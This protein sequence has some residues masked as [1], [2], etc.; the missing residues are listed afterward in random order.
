MELYTISRTT[1]LK[2]ELIE[3]FSSFIWT[4]R[5]S[6][7]GDFVVKLQPTP[8]LRA[9]LKPNV[10]LGFDESD[11]PMLI[12]T[13]L[14]TQDDDGKDVMEIKGRSVESVFIKRKSRPWAVNNDEYALNGQP[15]AI[16]TTLVRNSCIAPVASGHSSGGAIPGLSASIINIPATQP[17]VKIFVK[18]EPLYNSIKK[19]A[20]DYGFGFR[21]RKPVLGTQALRFEVYKGNDR[22]KEVVFGSEYDTLT[23][24][25]RLITNVDYYSYAY[26]F[27]ENFGTYMFAR[28]LDSFTKTGLDFAELVVDASDI[29]GTI[30]DVA[31]ELQIRGRQELSQHLEMDLLDGSVNPEGS[32]R[33]GTDY[34]LGDLVTIKDETGLL[35]KRQVSEHIW[36]YDESGYKSYP[37]LE[38]V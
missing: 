8:A 26:I 2:E 38:V 29:Q 16:I 31:G 24:T 21:V 17:T 34:F 15:Q 3:S 5:Y 20:D 23:D 12:N 32:F 27:N 1:Q 10:M 14:I 33:Y 7:F 6:A 9:A 36:S 4:D 13:V 35:Q 11:S 19:I 22:T 25:S 28:K 30:L 37:T 18:I